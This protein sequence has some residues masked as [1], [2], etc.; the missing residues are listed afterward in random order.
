MQEAQPLY[1][2]CATHP[3]LFLQFEML[4]NQ[5]LTILLYRYLWGAK[6]RNLQELNICIL[7]IAVLKNF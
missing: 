2:D 4:E 5:L 6:V 7:R 1:H 3:E